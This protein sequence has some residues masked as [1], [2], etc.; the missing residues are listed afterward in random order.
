MIDDA[1]SHWNAVDCDEAYQG[2][3]NNLRTIL[4]EILGTSTAMQS[5]PSINQY[6][7]FI[8]SFGR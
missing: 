7:Q 3:Q 1:V 4:E 5:S 6:S 2:R 8:N